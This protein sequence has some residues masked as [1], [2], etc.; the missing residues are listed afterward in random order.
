LW[1]WFGLPLAVFFLYT[2][3]EGI[4]TEEFL[5]RHHTWYGTT[6][7][8]GGSAWVLFGCLMALRWLSRK[9]PWRVHDV[10]LGGMGILAFA[11]FVIAMWIEVL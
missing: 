4:V 8:L 1:R 9:K 3:L 7:V 10:I 2:G 11:A 5:F 6:A